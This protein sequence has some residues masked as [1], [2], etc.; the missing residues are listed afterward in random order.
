MVANYHHCGAFTKILEILQRLAPNGAIWLCGGSVRDMALGRPSLD[1][2]ILVPERALTV[3]RFLAANLPAKLVILNRNILPT[4]RLVLQQGQIDITQWRAPSLQDDLRARDFT[5]NAMAVPVSTILQKPQLRADDFVDPLEGLEHLARQQLCLAAADS[6]QQDPL[7]ILRGYRL[8]AQLGF[9]LEPGYAP[10]VR[11]A[12]PLLAK[13]ARPRLGQEWLKLMATARAAR[14]MLAMDASGALSALIPAWEAGRNM[15]Q[16]PFHH[17]PVLAHNLLSLDYLEKIINCPQDF[18]DG[19]LAAARPEVPLAL[20]K[21]ATLLHDLGKPATSAL[22]RPGWHTFYNHDQ[23]GARQVLAACANLGLGPHQAGLVGELV[24]QHMLPH[25]LLASIARHRHLRRRMLGRFL[26]RHGDNWQSLMFM[27]W[28]DNMAGQGEAKPKQL[29]A[30]FMSIWREMAELSAQPEP[31]S[32]LLNGRELMALGSIA[33][34]PEV[35]RILKKL[36][37]Y[38]L[39]GLIHNREEALLLAQKWLGGC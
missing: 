37:Q 31:P 22:K 11:R 20:L 25:H 17:L 23:V 16:N 5:I 38:Q 36:R 19:A 34:G 39:E 26:H 30:E 9:E 21:T 4:A 2:D 3:A 13:I 10:A 24:A 27:A 32:P 12:L 28:A 33:P 1:L 18:L 35:G 6:L 8:Q 15:A 29:M 14:A 7:R